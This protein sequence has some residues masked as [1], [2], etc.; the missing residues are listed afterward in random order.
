MKTPECAKADGFEM[1]D[2]LTLCGWRVRSDWPLPALLPWSGDDRPV[3]IAIRT[4]EVP[5]RLPGCPRGGP[6]LQVSEEGVVR[7]AV[8]GVA[9]YLARGGSEV[10]IATRLPPDAPDV[11]LFLLGTI[12]GALCHQRGML[13]LHASCVA[14][15]VRAFAFAGMSGSGKSTVAAALVAQGGLLVSDDVMVVDLQAD[16]TP[17]I[18]PGV[19]RQKLWR[20]TLT[21]LGLP[22]GR[23]VRRT[24]DLEK[25]ERPAAGQ[26]YAAS[27]PLAAIHYLEPPVTG[28][29][30]SMQTITA[31][32]AF[33]ALQAQIYRHRIGHLLG[34]DFDMFAKVGKIAGSV[35]QMRMSMPGG[36]DALVAQLASLPDALRGG[37]R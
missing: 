31:R 34:R 20:D 13:P 37:A 22:A 16:G 18:L 26:Y 23:P 1:A 32:D 33:V 30:V 4:G 3:D 27:I 28:G 5:E 19:P 21:A 7:F 8:P 14:F 11:G 36:V 35:A 6:L 24:A 17:V 2:D 15:G 9:A 10:T 29:A 12:F 25:F